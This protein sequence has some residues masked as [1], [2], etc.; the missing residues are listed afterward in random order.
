MRTVKQIIL[1]ILVTLLGMACRTNRLSDAARI[2]MQKSSEL[3]AWLNWERLP[4][5]LSDRDPFFY[6]TICDELVA[7]CEAD[8]LLASL[9]ASNN[10]DFRKW[11]VSG[12]LYYIDD[13][14]IYDAFAGR[15]D[16]KEEEESYYV[17]HYLAKRGNTAA[18]ATL[19]RHYFKYPVSSWQWSYTAE[20]FGKYR[21][22][23]AAS[24]LVES[25][26]AASLNVS[27]AACNALREMFPD[28]P[29]YFSGPTEARAH[30]I[31]RLS[32]A[33]N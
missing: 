30:Y 25:L 4:K 3:I 6:Q 32:K 9:D 23:P 13:R 14:R 29:R 20:L 11:L 10:E 27:A 31:E 12:V 18:L 17:A 26:D 22:M 15:L 28:S 1:A 16:D 33:P 5:D 19:N 7:R 24:N 2:H 21:Y 8:F